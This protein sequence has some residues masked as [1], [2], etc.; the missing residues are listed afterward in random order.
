MLRTA[1]PSYA[2][3]SLKTPARL[4]APASSWLKIEM[5]HHL[6]DPVMAV[7][8]TID[9]KNHG[10]NRVDQSVAQLFSGIK[11]M[12]FSSDFS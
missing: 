9:I 11:R 1:P 4:A 8:Q 6:M 3:L 5:S 12:E 7:S 10:Q 2:I